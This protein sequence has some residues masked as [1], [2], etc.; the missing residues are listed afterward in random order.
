MEPCTSLA[1]N[2]SPGCCLNLIL[3]QHILASGSRCFPVCCGRAGEGAVGGSP[4]VRA[5]CEGT[6]C[7]TRPSSL[8]LQAAS[9]ATSPQTCWASLRV[10]FT[11]VIR[12]QF[13]RLFVL[14]IRNLLISS[15]SMFRSISYPCFPST[16]MFCC[17]CFLVSAVLFLS[18]HNFFIACS[19]SPSPCHLGQMLR[20]SPGPATS[21]T[22]RSLWLLGWGVCSRR[23][24][25]VCR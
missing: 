2:L 3:R 16:P 10:F 13:Q 15:Q 24:P 25:Q 8:L 22:G 5:G 21:P 12:K 6:G 18:S 1:L 11:S 20:G 14:K 4:P 9:P 23:P 7:F 17:P 19:R